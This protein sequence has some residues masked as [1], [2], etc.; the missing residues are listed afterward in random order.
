MSKKVTIACE[1]CKHKNYRLNK[2][3]EERLVI[4]KFCAKCGSHTSHKEEK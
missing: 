4:N 3:G 1:V 2:T